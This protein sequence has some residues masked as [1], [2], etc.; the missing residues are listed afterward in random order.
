MKKIIVFS[1]AIVCL[2]TAGIAQN[3]GSLNLAKGQKYQIEN[4]IES[5][6]T[7]EVQGQTIDRKVNVSS[8][9]SIEVK[10][11]DD[12]GF[13]LSNTIT[14]FKFNMSAMGQELNFDSD[15]KDDLSGEMGTALKDY[16]NLPKEV[17][18]DRAGNVL[19]G[20]SSD[21]SGGTNSIVK[22]LNF[23]SSG[24]GADLAFQ[25]LPAN[26]KVGSTWQDSSSANGIKKNTTYLV[27]EINANIATI[28]LSGTIST[29]MTMEQQ[30]MEI[31]SKTSG[32]FT[33]EE[34]VDIQSG[35]IQTNTYTGDQTGT[36]EAMGQEMAT[37]TK[38]TS[39]TTVKVL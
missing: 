33:G 15:N 12:Q 21:S 18:I 3:K 24:Y 26:I 29:T 39:T 2:S 16:I 25:N 6:T 11:K 36:L 23:E 28:S 1:T 8:V 10:D 35:V 34:T 4:K 17:K 7:T 22:Q 9:Y 32:K 14:G 30:G 31:S 13:N 37:S 27:K 38:A 19:P 20:K 5:N